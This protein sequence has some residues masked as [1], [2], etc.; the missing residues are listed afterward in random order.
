MQNADQIIELER[1]AQRKGSAIAEI[2]GRK[3]CCRVKHQNRSGARVPAA[4]FEL[5]GRRAKRE[6]V[7]A[8]ISA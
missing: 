6:E 8:A 3:V 7:Y 1:Q 2:N 5:D 4:Y